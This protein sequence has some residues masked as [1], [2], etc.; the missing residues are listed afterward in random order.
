MTGLPNEATIM[1]NPDAVS[2]T[3]PPGSALLAY[4]LAD[5][6]S[7]PSIMPVILGLLYPRT[8]N[9]L[10]AEPGV[11]K[12]WIA[13]AAAAETVARGCDV[14][15]LDH[16]DSPATWAARLRGLGVGDE[17]F[18][19]H[20]MYLRPMGP[21]DDADLAWLVRLVESLGGPLVIVDSQPEALALAGLDEDSAVDVTR[22]NQSLPRPLAHAGATV[23]VVDHLAK[24]KERG[25][26]A[27]GSG[28]K[29][30]VV[31]GAA[32]GLEVVEPFSRDRSGSAQITIS[33]DRH[34]ALG[35]V[36]EA[37]ATVA[38]AVAGGTVHAV[39]VRRRFNVSHANAG[40]AHLHR[41]ATDEAFS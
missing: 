40:P 21:L 24:G 41:S 25:R 38:F 30:A 6:A 19:D 9:T 11:G 13:A 36:G 5:A 23:L 29:L 32:L 16:E 33:K 26:W 1:A 12:S 35:G 17:A 31:D 8:V 4:D 22:W 20:V 28:A 7:G 15:I 10:A 34:G 39:S 37:V 18:T 3:P 14:I 2:L 27:R